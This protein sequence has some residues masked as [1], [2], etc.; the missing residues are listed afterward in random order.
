MTS[1]TDLVTGEEAD[2]DRPEAFAANRSANLLLWVIAAFFVVFVLWAALTTLER[3]VHASGR[4]MPSSR[5]QLVSNLEGGV[6]QEILVRPGQVVRKGDVLVRLSPTLSTAEYGSNIATTEALRAKVIRLTAEVR[7]TA[8]VFSGVS[9]EA[10]AVEL[11]LYRARQAELAG[12][13]GAGGARAVQAER[14][15]GEAQSVLAA[16]QS[17][18]TAAQR[19]RDMLAPL[20]GKQIVSQLDFVKAENAVK[21]AQS[22]VAAAQATVARASAAV[23][24]ARASGGQAR[25][26]WLGRSGAELA[27]AQAELNARSKSTPALADRVDRTTVRAPMNGRVNRVLVTTVGGSVSPG[28]PIVEVTPSDDALYVEASLRPQDVANVRIGQKAK[29]E[30][31]A[32]RSAVFGKLD[33]EVV[34]ISPDVVVNEKTGEAFYTVE[35]KTTSRLTDANGKLLP[36]GPGMM[37]NVSLLGDERSILSYIFTPFTQ[38]SENAFRE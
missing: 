36:I 23:A 25:S 17:N 22:E 33:G 5:M 8:P 13:S 3:T 19:E 38:L 28:A 32:Y 29:V 27:A 20:A 24:E 34:T 31:T 4:I 15:V 21:V 2:L 35:V 37:A 30:V 14:S 7:G 9:P 10:A 11:A 16:R 12:L 18:L 26:D 6:I 1:M